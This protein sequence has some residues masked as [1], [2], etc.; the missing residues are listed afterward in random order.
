LANA[1]YAVGR[2]KASLAARDLAIQLDND[3]ANLVI[4]EVSL[5][6]GQDDIAIAHF[7]AYLE[8]DGLPSNWVRKLVTGARDPATG[9]AY[10]DRRMPQIVASMPEEYAYDWQVNLTKWYLLFGFLDR[11]FELILDLDLTDSRW[12]DADVFVWSGNIYRRLGF[13]A[14]PKYLD[15]AESIGLIDVWEQRGA[16]DFCE[17]LNGQWV[18][19]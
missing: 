17:K 16:P 7:E 6:E 11:H 19:E 2:T 14:H 10:L 18:C 13:T 8:Q 9:Q 15:V 5:V 12:T 4:G 1:L 3:F